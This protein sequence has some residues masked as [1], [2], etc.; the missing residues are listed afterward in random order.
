MVNDYF[1][2]SGDKKF[3]IEILP[4]LET[5]LNWW[6]KNRTLVV[7]MDSKNEQ[8]SLYQYRVRQHSFWDRKG[9]VRIG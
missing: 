5:E 6:R 9:K 4:A 3:L 8:Y 7:R 1:E 2:A